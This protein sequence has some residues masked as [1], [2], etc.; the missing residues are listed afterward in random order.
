VRDHLVDAFLEREALILG[1]QLRLRGADVLYAVVAMRS[2]SILITTDRELR[3]RTHDHLIALT[4]AEWLAQ[5]PG[6]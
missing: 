4:P 5:Q 1:T 2:G 6:E 3:Q